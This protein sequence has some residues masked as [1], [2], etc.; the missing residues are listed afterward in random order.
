MELRWASKS[1]DSEA[2]TNDETNS[3]GQG[4]LVGRIGK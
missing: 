4:T 2:N 3:V 1:I